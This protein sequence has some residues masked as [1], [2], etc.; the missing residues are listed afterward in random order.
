ML[1]RQTK[2]YQ[3]IGGKKGRDCT[4]RWGHIRSHLSADPNAISIDIGSAEGFFSKETAI[5]TGG[6]VISI[7]GS[8]DVY[9]RQKK[10]CAEEIERGQIILAHMQLNHFNIDLFTSLKYQYCFLL[11]VL[12]WF[13]KPD[14]ILQKL[15]SASRTM[16]IE[17]PELDDKKSWNQPLLKRISKEYGNLENFLAKETGKNI[18]AEYKVSSH[19]SPFRR[20]FVM[21]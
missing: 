12:H 5:F 20:V 10:Y 8:Y 19:T 18:I 15:S 9:S 17:F 11:S 14:V 16:F 3:S 4:E 1:F 2:V 21:S 6:R 7:E 13:D